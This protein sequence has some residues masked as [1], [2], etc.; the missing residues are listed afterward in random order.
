MSNQPTDK[1]TDR[2][3]KSEDPKSTKKSIAYSQTLRINKLYYNRSDLHNNCKRLLNT[4]TNWDYYNADITTK[5]NRA[6]SIPRSKV[7]NETKTSNVER[8]SLTITYNRILPDFKT[9]ID[10]KLAYFTN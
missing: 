7:L 9:I 1:P 8:L 5:I 4:I 2:H 6:I 10:K 3:S